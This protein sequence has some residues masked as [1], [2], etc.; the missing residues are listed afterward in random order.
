MGGLASHGAAIISEAADHG[1]HIALEGLDK[2]VYT[3]SPAQ[4][5]LGEKI[6][7]N[8]DAVLASMNGDDQEVPEKPTIAC[9]LAFPENHTDNGIAWKFADKYHSQIRYV[10]KWNKW[11]VW[12]GRRWKQDDQDKHVTILARK[13]VDEL[14]Q[15]FSVLAQTLDRSEIGRIQTF[16]R[17]S[18]QQKNIAAMLMLTS[19]DERVV[20]HHDCL[21]TDPFLLNVQNGTVELRTGKLREHRPEDFITQLANVDYDESAGCS[22]WLAMLRLVFDG[23]DE[24]LRF[25]QQV[26]GYSITGDTGEHILPIAWGD[27]FNGKSTVWNAIIEL[28]GDYGIVAMDSLL[29]GSQNE[30]ATEKAHLYQKRI[31]AVSEPE[32]GCKLKESRV[33]ELTGDTFITARRMREDPWTFKRTHTFWLATNHLPKVSGLDEGIWRRIKLIPF[34][35]NLRDKVEPI[36]DF[37]LRLIEREGA[38]ILRWLVQGYA[39]YQANGFVVPDCVHQCNAEYRGDE[40]HLGQFIAE[41]C[42]TKDGIMSPAK[43]LFDAYQTWAGKLAWSRTAFGKALGERFDKDRPDAG[44][45]RKQTIYHGIGLLIDTYSDHEP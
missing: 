32:Q 1:I 35:V 23:D 37:H 44:A 36:P 9:W 40:D 26:L 13:F 25:V 10:P 45:F 11:L 12:D 15:Q 4:E 42:V 27:G 34:N 39:D 22:E 6:K 31:V 38:G 19:A 41:C 14:W 29:M 21:N 18:N 2:L 3:T 43:A 8:K 33:K 16:V 17:R 7:R 5:W 24:L 20:C 28:M 30:H